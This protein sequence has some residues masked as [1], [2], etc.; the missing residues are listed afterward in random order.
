LIKEGTGED[1]ILLLD[2]VMSELDPSRQERLIEGFG[3]NQ[4][5]VTSAGPLAAKAQALRAAK[6]ICIEGGRII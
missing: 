4:V 5:F 6:V 3:E 1:A 2:D